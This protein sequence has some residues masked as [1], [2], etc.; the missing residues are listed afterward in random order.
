M[1]HNSQGDRNQELS[2]SDRLR[3]GI[4]LQLFDLLNWSCEE[5]NLDRE[6]MINL[7]RSAY[8]KGYT[9]AHN[10]SPSEQG[11]LYIEIGMK[12][13]GKKSQDEPTL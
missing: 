3:L 2:R 6:G 13:P 12:V 4:D 7:M 9:D 11:K 10:E 8:A 5:D 1:P